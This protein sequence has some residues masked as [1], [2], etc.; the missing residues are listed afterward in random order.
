MEWVKM[1]ILKRFHRGA[2]AGLDSIWSVL[3]HIISGYTPEYLVLYRIMEK[4]T[5]S[6]RLESDKVSALDALADSM[7]RDRTYLLGEAVQAYLDT[8][9]WQLEQIEAGIAE[10]NA[11]QV[12]DRR[13]V[14]AMAS[15]WR[16]QK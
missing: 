2:Y 7:E 12:V 14:K 6:F 1:S 10:A 5:I 4:Q 16:R 3:R 13:K 15:K 11:G 9:Q 8:Q